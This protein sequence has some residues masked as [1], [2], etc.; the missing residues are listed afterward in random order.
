MAGD[1]L[2]ILQFADRIGLNVFA[3][4]TIGF[5]LHAAV[6]VVERDAFKAM[7]WRASP[8][9]LA[10]ALFVILRLGI[11]TSQIGDGTSL[12][13]T[14]LL[15]L[16]LVALGN[17]TLLILGGAI[18]ATVALWIGSRVFAAVGAIAISAGFGVT[19]HTQG[20]TE[21][22][23]AP[24]VAA[25]HVLIAGFWV[26][27]PLSL[28]PFEA[29]NKAQLLV[30]L[31]RFSTVAIAAIPILIGLGL[32]L[33]WLLTGT[34][35]R[36]FGTTYGLLLLAKL[37]VAM[38]A[39]AIGALNKQVVTAKIAEDEPTGRRWLRRTLIIEAALFITA[40]IAISAATTVGGPSE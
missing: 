19:G 8:V 9:A 1:G 16:A 18:T 11:L 28:Y 3:L 36:L 23:L 35:H 6:G 34:S 7:R 10:L 21:P 15:P 38:I 27:A 20:L 13:D 24:L 40:I 25:T 31:Q 12:F 30:R 37:A 14:E 39:V 2:L 5:A 26:A 32:W 4:L 22:G 33:A 17:S 29:L